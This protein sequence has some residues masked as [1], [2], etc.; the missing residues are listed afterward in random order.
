MSQ[1]PKDLENMIEALKN[2]DARIVRADEHFNAQKL[3]LFDYAILIKTTLFALF[4]AYLALGGP[5]QVSDNTYLWLGLVLR[6]DL[7]TACFS[8]M[9]YTG[10]HIPN[11]LAYRLRYRSP[12]GSLHIFAASILVALIS[13][14]TFSAFESRSTYELNGEKT[15]PVPRQLKDLGDY[16]KGLFK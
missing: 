11:V 12:S 6:L 3:N 5:L 10:T 8:V 1:V 15:L 2:P 14:G 7:I 9:M 16:F 4:G 13:Y